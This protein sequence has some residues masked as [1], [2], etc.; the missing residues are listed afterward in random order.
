M[1]FNM[2][3]RAHASGDEGLTFTLASLVEMLVSSKTSLIMCQKNEINN[4]TGTCHVRKLSDTPRDSDGIAATNTAF[5]LK[6]AI[7]V[8]LAV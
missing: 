7:F 3:L 4:P 2:N 6:E 1:R 5:W 8:F